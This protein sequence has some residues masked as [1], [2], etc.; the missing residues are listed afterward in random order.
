MGHVILISLPGNDY[1]STVLNAGISESQIYYQC[2]DREPRLPKIGDIDRVCTAL[3]RPLDII[4]PGPPISNCLDRYSSH[5]MPSTRFDR[6]LA[7][8]PGDS[9]LAFIAF[10][11]IR[12]ICSRNSKRS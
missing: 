5:Q 1:G 2:K 10:L 11:R 12:W 7:M 6:F 4:A 8:R 9:K 3:A